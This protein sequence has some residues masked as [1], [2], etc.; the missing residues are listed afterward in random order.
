M[1]IEALKKRINKTVETKFEEVFVGNTRPKTKHEK[2][3]EGLAKLNKEQKEANNYLKM[4]QTEHQKR[5][6]AE[7]KKQIAFEKK[8]QQKN[9]LVENSTTS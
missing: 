4:H 6:D 1:K 5:K 8:W 3:L 7:L 2:L 9:N